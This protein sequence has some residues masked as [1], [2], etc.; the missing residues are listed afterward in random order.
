M[1]LS[2]NAQSVLEFL[3]TEGTS[4]R[5]PA[6]LAKQCGVD[7]KSIEVACDELIQEKLAIRDRN[8]MRR[9]PAASLVAG[10]SKTAVRILDN[11][12]VDGT[13]IGGA[14]LRAAINL[15]NDAYSKG[16]RELQ[17]SNAIT[18]GPGRGGSIRRTSSIDP[19]P[20]EGA[21]T[22]AP[23]R[24]EK[25]LYRP[26]V[27]WLQSSWP[28]VSSDSLQEAMIT[29]TPRGWKKDSGTW[30]RADVIQLRVDRYEL[31]PRGQRT[32]LELSSYGIKPRGVPR[33]E[34]VFE[35]AAQARWAHRST[36]VI[37]TPDS[38]WAAEERIVNEVRRFN[39]GLYYMTRNK[40]SQFDVRVI[41]E[42][43]LQSPEPGDLE[44]AI[45][46]FISQS[47]KADLLLRYEGVIG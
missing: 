20:S 24:L 11:T 26:F 45:R 7:K 4:F 39:L 40:S 15:D 17:Q 21:A 47:G 37:E 35:A 25:D 34:W 30:T 1:P 29:A 36:L 41:L 10:L 3:P 32:Q 43:G 44:E 12:P 2:A 22:V 42:P 38:T 14:A 19:S 13:S 18:V 46:R 6:Y 5:N 8:R 33:V 31:L 23:A 27:E 9:A 16:L 28:E